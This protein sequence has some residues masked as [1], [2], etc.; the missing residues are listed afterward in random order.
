M[1]RSDTIKSGLERAHHRALL[2]ALGLGSEDFGKPF[3]GIAC[4]YT[5]LV[6]GHMHLD[7]LAEA[8]KE[9]VREAGGVPFVFNTV[10]ICDG[11][12]M[13][14]IGMNFSLPSRDWIAD[15]VELMV[16]AHRLDGLVAIASCDKILPGMLMAIARLNIPS[17]VVTGGPMLSG[18][19]YGRTHL[20][21]SSA[22]EAV[23]LYR[24]GA[25]SEEEY[26][27]V[28]E[29]SCP[30]C[31]SCNG[32]FTANTMACLTEALG[33]ALPYTA[34]IPAVYSRRFAL[35]RE[36]G[37]RIVDLVREDL[38]PSEILSWKSFYNA[39]VVDMALGGSTNTVLHIPAIA[40]ECGVE[41]SL[42]LFD[43]VSRRVPHIC[44]LIGLG[45]RYDMLDFH[46]AGGVPALLVELRDLLYLDTMTVTGKTLAENIRGAK[47]LD[48]RVIHP[49]DSPIHPEGGIAILRGTLAPDGAVL[50]TAGLPSG[51]LNF[52][53]YAKV[54]DS[55]EEALKIVM[56]GG[57]KEYDILVVRY[58]GP[59]GGP[60][61]PEM[62]Q[63]TAT[64]AGMG[65]SDRVG[66]ITDGRFSGATHGLCIG[67]VSPEAA[68]GGPIAL[69][70]DGDMITVDVTGRRLELNVSR[71]ELDRRRGR[72]KPKYKPVKGILLRYVKLLRS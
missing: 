14:H 66:L 67:H 15:S 44:D 4:S 65:L 10:A 70:E 63:I 71:E 56:D 33:L 45:G 59:I 46:I 18:S 61:M 49:I 13:G 7:R 37:R 57:L 72:W 69:V 9:G 20:G 39:I 30:T 58:E 28:E 17:I 1:L 43:Q 41:I 62:L 21:I 31:G 36:A 22:A 54:C 38:K 42:D 52:R 40:K 32:L 12:A 27:M 29:Y 50:K 26:R 53:G 8:V 25:I 51:M 48:R 6:P 5:D 60:G 47:V 19:F 64:V 34:T 16:E 24:R 2:R 35:A 3:I 11:I 55:E 23:G 68:L